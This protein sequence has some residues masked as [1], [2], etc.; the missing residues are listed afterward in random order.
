MTGTKR[1][2]YSEILKVFLMFTC[3]QV[4]ACHTCAGAHGGEKGEPEPLE[5][6]LQVGKSRLG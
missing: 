2:C 6:G 5:L 3:V 1:F 4:S